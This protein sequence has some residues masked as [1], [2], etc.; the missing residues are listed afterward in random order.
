MGKG[1]Y[2]IYLLILKNGN[3]RIIKNRGKWVCIDFDHYED[4]DWKRIFYKKVWEFLI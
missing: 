2:V 4:K 3:K 1:M